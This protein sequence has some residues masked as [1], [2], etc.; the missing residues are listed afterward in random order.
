MVDIPDGPLSNTPEFTSFPS[1]PEEMINSIALG[2]EDDL[3]IVSRYGMAIEDYR[4]LEKQPWFQLRVAQ[5]RSDFEKN[6]ITF[7]AKAGWMANDLLNKVYIQASS[8]DAPLSQV[9]DVLKTLI[10]A[11]GLEP[12]EEKNSGSSTT[13]SIQIDLGEQSINISNAPEIIENVPKMLEK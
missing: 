12:K 1:V 13:F 6:G 4:E 2:L 5:L 9:H 7:K 10:K 8:P 11:S 3:I